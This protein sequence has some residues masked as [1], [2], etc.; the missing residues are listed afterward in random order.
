MVVKLFFTKVV[1]GSPCAKKTTKI[2]QPTKKKQKQTPR[3]G[4]KLLSVP[5]TT[6]CPVILNIVSLER[7]IGSTGKSCG[8]CAAEPT[9]QPCGPATADAVRGGA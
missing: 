7:Y 3:D 8:D 9:G 2:N 1:H 5:H 6:S 4:I